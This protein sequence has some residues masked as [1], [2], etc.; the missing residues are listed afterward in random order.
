MNDFIFNVLP[1]Q[2]PTIPIWLPILGG[3]PIIKPIMGSFF[4]VLAAF[5]INHLYQ[6]YKDKKDKINYIDMI[7]SEIEDSIVV[8]DQDFVQSLPE[9]KWKSAV[10]SGALRLFRIET[11]LQSLSKNYYK[12]NDF[13]EKARMQEF[14]GYDWPRLEREDGNRLPI[15]R[16]RQILQSRESLK[17]ELTN[18]KN[19]TWLNPDPVHWWQLWKFF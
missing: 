11:E 7:R 1:A 17:N 12:I 4:G 9:D 2:G 16:V 14:I 10:N 6:S 18:L 5:G 19:E 13:N 8:L 15:M 3:F